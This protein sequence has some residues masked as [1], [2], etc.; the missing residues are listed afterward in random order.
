MSKLRVY[1]LARELD[2][3]SKILM[4][5]LPTLGIDVASHQST[6]TIAD[7]EKIRA[8]FQG[9][10]SSAKAET[11]T[12]PKASETVKVIR[13]RRASD[14]TE[15]APAPATASEA[16]PSAAVEAKVSVQEAPVAA[17]DVAA[18]AHPAQSVEASAVAVEPTSPAPAT[19]MRRP[20]PPSGGATI[21]RRATPEEVEADK[22][23]RE[24]RTSDRGGRREDSRGTRVTS[25]G[26]PN[27]RSAGSYTSGPSAASGALPGFDDPEMERQWSK[28]KEAKRK[29]GGVDSEE[30][31]AAAARRAAA[32]T[33]KESQI[34]TRKLLLEID[35][36]DDTEFDLEAAPVEEVVPKTTVYTPTASNKRRDLRRRKDLKKTQVTQPRA[37][38]RVVKMT[39]DIQVGE[40]ARQM[41]LKA[42]DLIKKLMAQGV[43]VTITNSIDFDTA[44]LIANEYGFEVQ[45][46]VRTVE[47]ILTEAR[48]AAA[49]EVDVVAR[50]PIVTVMGHVDH[51][52]TSILDAIRSSKV[53]AGEAGGIT[54]AI[55]AYTVERKNKKIAFLDTPG[56]E[57]FSN[58]RARGAKVT[59]IVVLVVAADDG[60]MPQTKEA[61][62]HARAANVPIIVAINK[63]DKP[64]I[65]LERVYSELTEQGIQSE[66]WGGETQ[67]V[68]VSALKHEGIDE[69]L[70][71]ILLQAEVLDL[72]APV[73]TPAEGLVVEAHLDKGRGPV[74]T[75]MTQSGFLRV[76]DFIVAGTAMGKVRSMHDHN[77][78][79][80]SEAGPSTPVEVIGLTVVPLA[81]DKVNVVPD[82]KTAR[83]VV[84]TRE[85]L[86]H[87]NEARKSSA[88]TLDDLLGK[89]KASEAIELPV[90]VKADTQGSVE[91]LCESLIKLNS[92]RVSNRIVHRAVGGVTE[93]DIN[94]ALTTKAII[95]AFNVRTTRGLDEE[96]E[97]LGV[98]VRYSSIIYEVVDSIK[99]LMA[100]RLPPVVKE[101]VLG[102][103]EVRSPFSIPKI[104]MIAGS[105]VTDGKITRNSM[106][107]LIRDAIVIYAG[108]IGSLKR[109]KD[110]VR[111]VQTGYECGIGIE[112]YNDIREGD[113]IEAYVLEESPATLE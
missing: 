48:G 36:E 104:G 42:A 101:V 65:N 81:G 97:R 89:I 64:N 34:N 84:R 17:E 9:N 91:A 75:I 54:Q 28:K 43:M 60:V 49:T 15:E 68:K 78:K 103:A 100:G 56:H 85:A 8:A 19:P 109:F 62:S 52:K 14:T 11:M 99:A 93:S 105:A 98:M 30:E 69:L 27:V 86:A 1:E 61:V 111:E 88:Q 113:V 82:E 50:P 25:F 6:L 108:K 35:A 24:Q 38:Y 2:V 72:K 57:A 112:G 45:S 5:R 13:R 41:S 79:P 110:D 23:R 22:L 51:G 71:A 94:L 21:V 4:S 32:K 3:D 18:A 47:D 73:N 37:A 92:S 16:A 26:G 76:G 31:I 102:H 58:M 29:V 106:V 77:A 12:A 90:I 10:A 46:V 33:K 55:G 66:E 44:T 107:R 63:I 67:F 95:V 20:P 74:A 39:H 53:A 59:D 80:I 96:A 70:E 87:A 83:D 7:A 40:L